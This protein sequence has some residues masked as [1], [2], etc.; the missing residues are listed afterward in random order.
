MCG[1]SYIIPFP[2]KCPPKCEYNSLSSSSESVS[3]SS[4]PAR[5][6]SSSTG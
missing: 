1:G 6:P 3:V 4:P 5:K 2:L